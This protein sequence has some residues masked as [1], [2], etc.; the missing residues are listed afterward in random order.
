MAVAAAP[1]FHPST[2]GRP[3]AP[4]HGESRVESLWLSF[5]NEL[6]REAISPANPAPAGA[7][8]DGS[9]LPD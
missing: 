7:P 9:A 2:E 4:N 5:G 1:A 6:Q 3:R 8:T